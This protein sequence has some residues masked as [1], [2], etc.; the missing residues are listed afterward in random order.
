MIVQRFT[1]EADEWDE[2]VDDSINGTF[3]HSRQ[4]LS[5]HPTGR[6]QDHSLL[7]RGQR[8]QLLAV[9][10]AAEVVQ[11]RKRILQSHPG[12]SYGGLVVH[13]SSI[14]A[15]NGDLVDQLLDYN[16]RARFEV[17]RMRVSEKVFHKQWCEELD[18]ALFRAGFV[19]EGREL[20]CAVDLMGLTEHNILDRFQENGRGGVKKA[21]K[22]GVVARITDDYDGFWHILKQNLQACYNASPTHS[23]EEILHL[24]EMFGNRVMLIGGFLAD[25]L[26][27]GT[28]IFFLNGVAAH[29]MY[30]A[31]DYEHQRS[32]SLNL[33]LYESLLECSRRR[34]R[35][36]N[37]GICTNPGTL[38]MELNNGV[39][40]FKRS[41]GGAGV[42]RDL[43]VNYLT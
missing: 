10:P 8:N 15:I 17:I 30:M 28:V 2:F 26:V 35:Y 13:E 24:K 14:S 19:I 6:F 29:T 12:A 39:F 5:Y 3:M 36:L 9:L 18:A 37:Y 20:S 32:R 40:A 21:Q 41:C 22:H 7:F 25:Q 31:Q 34:M 1:D 11:D 43:L 38:G 27:S 33:V 23:L 42:V 16:K 4:F